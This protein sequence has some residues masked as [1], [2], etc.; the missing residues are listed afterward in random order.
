MHIYTD[1]K[2]SKKDLRF[3]FC[4]VNKTFTKMIVYGYDNETLYLDLKTREA[5]K[6]VKG[7]VVQNSFFEQF[8]GQEYFELFE[9][10]YWNF[11]WK[12]ITD[13]S[14]NE[15][16]RLAHTLNLLAIEKGFLKSTLFFK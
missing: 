9:Q 6:T 15:F 8:D 12:K 1:K 16:K 11:K 14:V 10:C 7:E 5:W 4:I 2:H 3:Y 13:V